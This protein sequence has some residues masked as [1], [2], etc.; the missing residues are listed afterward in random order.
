LRCL[1]GPSY[2]IVTVAYAEL[3]FTNSKMKMRK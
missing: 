2:T 3:C 1:F